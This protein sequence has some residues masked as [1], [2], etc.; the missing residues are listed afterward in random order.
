MLELSI[1]WFSFRLF[2]YGTNCYLKRIDALILLLRF[3]FLQSL[4]R[5]LSLSLSLHFNYD[6]PYLL[7]YVWQK[8]INKRK[9]PIKHMMSTIF[10]EKVLRNLRQS[11]FKRMNYDFCFY[12]HATTMKTIRWKSIKTPTHSDKHERKNHL[13]TVQ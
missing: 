13:F 12:E 1:F 7:V 11:I 9:S 10:F 3:Y 4:S 6:N 2:R 5:S 8:I